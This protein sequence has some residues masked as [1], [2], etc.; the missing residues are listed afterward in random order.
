MLIRSQL[1]HALAGLSQRALRR[2][3]HVRTTPVLPECIVD[4][5]TYLN[6]ASNDYLGLANH[7]EVIMA[8]QRAAN[9][10]GVGSGA[11]HVVSGHTMV[12]HALEEDLAGFLGYPRVLVFSTGYMA[13]VGV[14]TA[15]ARHIKVI[16]QD[17][18]NHASLIDGSRL[19]H[20]PL[21]R[22]RHSS[23]SDLSRRLANY[24][25][26]MGLVVSDGVFSVEGDLAPLPELS[27]TTHQAG[28]LLMVDDAH[29]VG[30][31]GEK[32]QG[33]LSYFQLPACAV[34]ILVGTFGKAFGT[35]GAFVAAD[36]VIIETLLQFSR[37][38]TY[39]TALPPAIAAATAVSLQLLQT[40]TWRRHH[41]RALIA[42][43]QAGAAS[44]GLAYTPSITAIQ[45]IEIGDPAKALDR[46]ERLAAQGIRVAVMRP[47][48]TMPHH[49]SLR[50]TLT[51]AH[52]KRQ[53][54]RLLECLV[55]GN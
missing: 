6:F 47:P 8:F 42:Y 31:L 10:Y 14:I 34:D 55:Q 33:S 49:S 22:Y 32:G 13:N 48:T 2:K 35:F 53:V 11:S 50:I 44:L 19:A 24:S 54:D 3:R 27:Q 9:T 4:G 17:K 20:R 41:L 43:F 1:E 36:E 7:P 12:H 26:Q 15:L 30:V 18:R 21:E 52:Q 51:A 40:E 38:Y 46:G 37:S 25:T 5:K 16:F 45:C 28:K 23:M 29:G 39:T